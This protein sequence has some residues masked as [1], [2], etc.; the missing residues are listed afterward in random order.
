MGGGSN[1]SVSTA[2]SWQEFSFI[3]WSIAWFFSGFALIYREI[4]KTLDLELDW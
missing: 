4:K 3:L 1:V 2:Q